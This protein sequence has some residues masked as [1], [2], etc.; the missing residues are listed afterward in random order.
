MTQNLQRVN[1]NAGRLPNALRVAII[2]FGKIA[3]AWM[4]AIR[5]NPAVKLVGFSTS[6]PKIREGDS[7]HLEL[8]LGLK[9]YLFQYEGMHIEPN[10]VD[11]LNYE[12]IDLFVICAP[13]SAHEKIALAIAL[14]GKHCIIEKPIAMTGVEGENI[15]RVFQSS[16]GKVAV[17]HVLPSFPEYQFLYQL[18]K[19]HKP[20]DV[21]ALELKR[22]VGWDTVY[23][24]PA[25]AKATGFAP[26][27]GIHDV[28]FLLHWLQHYR[29]TL[30]GGSEWLYDKPQRLIFNPYQPDLPDLR[31]VV[32]VGAN[33]HCAGFKHSWNLEFPD[34]TGFW[35]D[36][37]TVWDN[38]TAGESPKKVDITTMSV[39]EI[40]GRELTIMHDYVTGKSQDADFCN[41]EIAVRSLQKM[42]I[43]VR[44]AKSK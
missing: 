26:D 5:L 32:D 38:S 4:E 40:F 21:R 9:G 37:A 18:L 41:A 22:Y 1:V 25:I 23:V 30:S 36:G 8:N 13:T 20:A 39:G 10:W 15:L 27:L 24:Q 29:M 3:L 12:D 19:K 16:K 34:G 7:T 44:K 17:G 14:R 2:G 35:F 28:N 31:V 43:A 11:L 42:E 33:R 6:D